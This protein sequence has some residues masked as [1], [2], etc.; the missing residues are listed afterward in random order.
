M[1]DRLLHRAA[2]VGIDGP[3]YR[4]RAH[5]AHAGHLRNGVNAHAS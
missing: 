4:L 2:V 5:Q 1:L 3:S